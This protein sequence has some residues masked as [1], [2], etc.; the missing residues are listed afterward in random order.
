MK[1]G[2]ENTEAI[3]KLLCLIVSFFAIIIAAVN[4]PTENS[5]RKWEK[6]WRRGVI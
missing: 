6:V 1:T 5:C 2:A 3:S 4:L